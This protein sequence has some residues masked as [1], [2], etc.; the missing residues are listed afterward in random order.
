MTG[1]MK[2]VILLI[3][4]MACIFTYA[5]NDSTNVCFDNRRYKL[6]KTQNNFISL[7]LDTRT[8]RLWMV[9]W[10][11]DYDHR[12]ETVLSDKKWSE[13][14][15]REEKNGRYELYSTTNI[16]NS[17]MLDTYNGDTFQV[18]WSFDGLDNGV[19]IIGINREED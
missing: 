9:Q 13:V 2:K 1:S 8:G 7:K 19:W 10:S 15:N 17:L 14:L 4:L 3:S 6:Y 18:Q 5:Q 12:F 16:F 11:L